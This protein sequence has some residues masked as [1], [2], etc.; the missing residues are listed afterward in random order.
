[1]LSLS[2]HPNYTYLLYMLVTLNFQSL[3]SL[4]SLTQFTSACSHLNLKSSNKRM[5]SSVTLI[6]T[7]AFHLI[8]IFDASVLPKALNIYSYLA[9]KKFTVSLWVSATYC[10]YLKLI[11]KRL[12]SSNLRFLVLNLTVKNKIAVKVWNLQTP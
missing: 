6:P 2:F 3:F 11:F 4:F 7:Y 1:M 5:K 12:Y 10:R 9:E 8:G